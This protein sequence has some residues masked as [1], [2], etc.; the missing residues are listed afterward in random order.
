MKRIPLTE[1]EL[2]EQKVTLKPIKGIQPETYIK[3]VYAFL[4][5]LAL[6]LVFFLPGILKNGTYYQFSTTP[7]GASV[8]VDGMRLGATPGRYFVPRGM[9]TITL[10]TPYHEIWQED[11]KIKG[12]V[13]GTLFLKRKGTMEIPLTAAIT[14]DM[15]RE[16]T[17]LTASW[18]SSDEGYSSQPLPPMM[19]DFL[20]A[21]F[22]SA[23]G[24]TTLSSEELEKYM[25]TLLR[26]ASQKN[27]YRQWQEGFGLYAS[28][29]KIPG[30]GNLI[31]GALEGAAFLA[32]N[33]GLM[34]L[35]SQYHELPALNLP[36]S[37]GTGSI[38]F[39]LEGEVFQPLASDPLRFIPVGT[40][41]INGSERTLLIADRE[42]TKGWYY[43]FIEAN[44]S[45]ALSSKDTLVEHGLADENYLSDW[46][47]AVITP[48][49]QEPLRFVS[50]YA[51]ETFNSWFTEEYLS[52][53]TRALLPDEWEWQE[54]ALAN[55]LISRDRP[56]QKNL[57][58]LEAGSFLPGG[59]DLYDLEGNL[60]E[61]CRNGFGMND[62]SMYNTLP[63]DSAA[64]PDRAVRGGSWANTPGQVKPDT[65]G[66]QPASWCTAYIGFRPMLLD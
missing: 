34:T 10:K 45:W 47:G 41:D 56:S 44:P 61:W 52:G 9:R 5:T 63:Q 6:F 57:G 66:S 36:A 12:R 7:E 51:A 14:E 43:R 42:I 60:W 25:L 2:N 38:T 3:Y 11:V 32:E 17:A 37:S 20:N 29:G 39:G 46:D 28:K 27:A 19:Q 65:R 23:E 13:F 49:N 53:S 18:F 59:L 55:G 31:N 48:E 15:T 8:Y 4:G 22:R 1:E 35:L 50:V 54:I 62:A 21:N 16:Q 40:K 30:F 58:A 64:L 24:S 33:P 26:T